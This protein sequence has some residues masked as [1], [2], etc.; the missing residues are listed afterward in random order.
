MAS[1]FTHETRIPGPVVDVFD[2]HRRPTALQRLTPP[3][4][5]A[6]IIEK[7]DGIEDNGTTLLRVGAGPFK[8][9]WKAVHQDYIE[10]RQF[11]D[12]QLS[13]PFKF[14]NH[15]HSFRPVSANE[16][17][18]NDSIKYQLPMGALGRLFGA[19]AVRNKLERMFSYRHTV[20]QNDLRHFVRFKKTSR[21]HVA[22]TGGNGLIGSALAVFLSVQGHRVSILSRSGRSKVFGLRGVQWDPSKGYIDPNLGA[23]DAWIHLA[24]ENL[25]D[26]RWTKNRMQAI[27]ASRTEVTRFLSEY[28]LSQKKAPEVFISASGTGFY[29]STKTDT[30][31][32]ASRGKGFLAEVC[33]SWE[34]ASDGLRAAGI[35]RVILRTGVVLDRNGGALEKLLPVFAAGLG[36]RVGKGDQFWGWIAMDDL[37]RIYDTAICD[38]AMDGVFNTVAPE[39]VTNAEFSKTLGGVLKRPALLPVPAIVLKAMIGRMAEE[40]LLTGQKAIPERLE[41][42]GFKF[43]FP[44]LDLA[45]RHCLGK[46]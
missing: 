8:T 9:N 34:N 36:G 1:S 13:G 31:E 2:Y 17:V 25:S 3:W 30:A 26:G 27:R 38:Q 44:E 4:E 21:L 11:S 24:G 15:V 35:R 14:W 5:G 7:V 20:T 6:Q 41:E 10:N 16:T 37:L 28:I 39:V 23:V 45:L 29:G 22:I 42:I 18:L 33:E 12:S 43:D 32:S 19:R 46:Y 40:A